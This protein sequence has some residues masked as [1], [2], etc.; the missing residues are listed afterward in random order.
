MSQPTLKV[1][2]S[3]TD[4]PLHADDYQD[5]SAYVLE[6]G[7]DIRRG[8]S[9][10]LEDMRAGTA[11]IALLNNDRR[12]DPDYA[13][14]PYYPN[15]RPMQKVR[16]S[17][18]WDG[19][20]Y[21]QIVVYVQSWQ[22]GRPVFGKATTVITCVDAL[23]AAFSQAR[24]DDYYFFEN[25]P[26]PSTYYDPIAGAASVNPS[27]V[28]NPSPMTRIKFQRNDAVGTFT[29]TVFGETTA[30]I[31]ANP[32]WSQVLAAVEALS[33]IEPGT[34]HTGDALLT[35]NQGPFG[36]GSNALHFGGPYIGV[37]ISASVSV[38]KSLS[39]GTLTTTV[40]AP[41]TSFTLAGVIG[42]I[43]GKTLEFSST[44]ASIAGVLR[45]YVFGMAQSTGNIGYTPYDMT[46]ANK[47]SL[48]TT[49]F[50][51][52]IAW[53]QIYGIIV[54]EYSNALDIGTLVT[55][56]VRG[57]DPIPA[58]LSGTMF[59]TVAR[60]NGWRPEQI[61]A[62]AGD[63]ILQEIDPIGATPIS[64]FQAIAKAEMGLFYIARDGTLTFRSRSEALA[65]TS[66]GT[67]GNPDDD[68]LPIEDVSPVYDERYIRNTIT[69]T[70]E[71]GA[72]QTVKDN[73]SIERYYPRSLEQSGL[74]IATDEESLY[75]AQF[76]LLRYK[77][78]ATRITELALRGDLA[79]D[80]LWP[81]LLGA[82]LGNK[83]T[84]VYEPIAGASVSKLLTLESISL[85]IRRG[86]WRIVWGVSSGG[87][88]VF[89][90][91]TSLLDGT[92]VLLY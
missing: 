23:G 20:T 53:E 52:A 40:Q 1:E 45:F 88:S 36:I 70:N 3:F 29:I 27:L 78:P 48:T 58:A 15:V 7:T 26:Y 92:D 41:N 54:G 25:L 72:A 16:I 65:G 6:E 73:D 10:E 32:L 49:S 89:I 43:G 71:G 55:G 91:D 19:D 8:R 61:D 9:D 28:G 5:V 33:V 86:D 80:T 66:I 75:R 76:L 37:D 30:P 38:A 12:F 34:L 90:L 31:N 51:G 79:P 39:S 21:E 4:T 82:E 74:L 22:A 50:Y 11:T 84:V 77:E 67:F 18:I 2:I 83:Y 56:L 14:S 47:T 46:N 24:I 64:L 68:Y 81:I 60:Q 62:S 85:T 44:D 13:S 35:T 87:A 69:V 17:G 63:S 42:R 59:T 57:A